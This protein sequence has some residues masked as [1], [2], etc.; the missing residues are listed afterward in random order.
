MSEPERRA[1]S[2]VRPAWAAT[3][4]NSLQL[5]TPL[6]CL[7]GPPRLISFVSLRSQKIG[8]F[9]NTRKRRR[10]AA[11]GTVARRPA[12]G[13]EGGGGCPQRAPRPPESEGPK[14][15]A[16]CGFVPIFKVKSGFASNL[17][18][19]FGTDG[20]WRDRTCHFIILYLEF[21]SDAWFPL[22]KK[23]IFLFLTVF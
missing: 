19:E 22:F 4:G 21:F 8:I 3:Q 15:S 23:L 6:S 9:G 11:A 14:S 20:V 18:Q 17:G 5:Q 7:L 1:R 2:R 16:Q 13:G 12:V 10:C